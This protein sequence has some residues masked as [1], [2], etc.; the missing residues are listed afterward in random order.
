MQQVLA[1]NQKVIASRN[2]N[3]FYLPLQGTGAPSTP[4]VSQLAPIRA[5]APTAADAPASD[6]ARPA[7]ADGRTEGR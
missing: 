3:V 2:N 6:D 4:P 1:A 7:R 5:A